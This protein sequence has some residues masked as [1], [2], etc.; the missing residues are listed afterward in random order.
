MH[1]ISAAEANRHFSTVLRRVRDG[2]SYTVTSHGRAVAR[3]V[4]F[5]TEHGVTT[6]AR[7]ALFKRLRASGVQVVGAWTREE[8]YEDR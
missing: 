2:R 3:I 8:L 5:R 6:A 7:T 1:A 4:P